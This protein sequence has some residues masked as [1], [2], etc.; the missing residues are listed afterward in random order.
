M[1]YSKFGWDLKQI[2]SYGSGSF[3]LTKSLSENDILLLSGGKD[4]RNKSVS[5][6]FF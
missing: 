6:S 1:Q 5:T 2:D 3:P 4:Q